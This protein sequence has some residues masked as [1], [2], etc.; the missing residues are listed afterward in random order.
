MGPLLFAAEPNCNFY[1]RFCIPFGTWVWQSGLFE[2][3]MPMFMTTADKALL[4]ILKEA[5]E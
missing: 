3:L 1:T 5:E 4:G 2:D